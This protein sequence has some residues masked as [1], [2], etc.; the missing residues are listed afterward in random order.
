MQIEGVCIRLH[1][2][3]CVRQ[4]QLQRQ[5]KCICV[6][7]MESK[8]EADWIMGKKRRNVQEGGREKI[9]DRERERERE[10]E[11]DTVVQHKGQANAS[12]RGADIRSRMSS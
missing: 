9:R 5:Q 7:F 12:Q 4:L 6:R 1:A 3:A 10:R 2:C 8:G 11:R